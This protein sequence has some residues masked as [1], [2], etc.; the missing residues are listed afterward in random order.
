MA[1]FFS[2]LATEL[3]H[4][5]L[6]RHVQD[7]V[8][9]HADPC[10]QP[11]WNFSLARALLFFCWGMPGNTR[12]SSQSCRWDS[13][14]FLSCPIPP[15]RN[16]YRH[17]SSFIFLSQVG[18]HLPIPVKKDI[19]GRPESFIRGI[20][21]RATACTKPPTV[22]TMSRPGTNRSDQLFR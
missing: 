16:Q 7:L 20:T 9:R 19:P 2:I 13:G 1:P 5:T 21:E 8:I 22:L 14:Q 11:E 3:E 6:A 17:D 10:V 4:L 15:E 12:G 18:F